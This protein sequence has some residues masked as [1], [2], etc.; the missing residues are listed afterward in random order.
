MEPGLAG[1][2]LAGLASFASPCVLPLTPA[3]LSFIAGSDPNR[4]MA[5]GVSE[6][7]RLL[8]RALAFVAG[9]STVFVLLGATASA[10]GRFIAVWFDQLAV[11]AG[12]L[13]IVLGLHIAGWLRLPLLMRE[14]RVHGP[15][16]VTSLAGAYFVGL[17]FAFGWTPCVGPVLASILLLS[18]VQD[19]MAH[20]AILLSAY[21]A[22]LGLP[23]LFAAAFAPWFLKRTSRFS[24]F[25]R[26]V[27]IVAG[28]LLVVTGALIATG[29]FGTIGVWML[30]TFPV[31][32]RIG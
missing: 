10:A 9:F 26:P 12:V 20:G 30:E 19:S 16:R 6:R 15:V 23:F 24:R 1:A 4:L 2:F 14:K 8:V 25:A 28:V 27:S 21:A 32:G 5:A 13:L 18:G 7:G 11:I 17:A 29:Y 3:Y 22:G 31:F